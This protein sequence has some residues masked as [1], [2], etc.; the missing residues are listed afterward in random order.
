VPLRA[1]IAVGL[2]AFLASLM[3][4]L[5]FLGLA[6]LRRRIL[7]SLALLAVKN[8]LPPPPC[9]GVRKLDG[10]P[11]H[12]NLVQKHTSHEE[13]GDKESPKAYPHLKS[14]ESIYMCPCAPFYRKMKGLLHSEI[15]LESREYS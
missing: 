5:G 15:T 14:C 9:W 7:H 3:L 10:V 1:H 8:G 12:K 6:T 13:A 11:E 4:L 2:L